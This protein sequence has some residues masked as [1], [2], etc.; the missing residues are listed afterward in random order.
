MSKHILVTSALPYANGSIHLGHILEAVQTDIWV[1]FQKL[2]GNE[3]YFFCADDTHGTPIMI[4][5]KKAGKTPESMIEE[6]QKEHYKDLT[7]F[8]VEYDNYYT[9]NSEENKKFSESIY[10]TLKKNG[11]IVARNI[12]QSYCEHDKMFLPDRFIKGTC[13]K[14]G[15]KDQYGDSCEV[16]GTSYSPKDLKDSY[17][18]ICGTTP[19]LRES[20]H[21]FFKLQDFQNQL[22]T[23]MEEGNRLNEGAQ[24]KLQEWFTSGLQEWDI[25]RDG[26]YFGFAIPEEENKYFYVW[27]DAPIGYM[28]SSLNHLKD[29]KKFN[30]FWKEGKG[31]IVHFIGKDILY[32]HGLFWPAMLMGSGYKAPSQLNVHGFLTVN[33][34][35][36][37][38]S[39]GTFINASTFA[40]YLDVE[41]FRFYLACRLGSGMED[42]DISFDDFVSRVNSDLIGNLVNLVSRVSTSILDKMDRKLG[43]LSTEGKSLVSELL[44]KETEIREAYE[45]RNYSKVMRE[46]TGLGD[47]V[48]KYVND[49][50]P[51]NL[52]KTDVEKAREVVTTSLNCAKI[53]FTYL[54]PVT[55]KIVH[56]LADLF[57]IPNLS[58]L[59]LTETIENKVLGPYQML[60][61]RVEEKNITIMITETKETFE[62]SNPEKAKQDPSKSNTNEV[63]SATVSEDGFITIDELSKV[64]L[65]VGLIKEA[66]P[67]EGADKLLFVKVDLGE[68]GI[69]NVFAGIKASYTA[70]E[71]VGKKVVVVANLKPR[72][73]KF[74]LSEAMLLA[75]GKDKTLSLFVPDRDASPG[76]LLK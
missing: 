69:K 41:H 29:E 49:Y 51:W 8:G 35:K 11:H 34:E 58:F 48:N 38:K 25:S 23:W 30:E 61:K 46:I 1:R 21:L 62:K 57:Q 5:A 13:P 16:C 9:T 24:K 36:M 20:K 2:I 52:I 71:L 73:M 40:K 75:S 3:C 26:P 59:N 17:C 76:D 47:K 54:A 18:S 50:A 14:C 31:E 67:V 33:G 63:K 44:S 64:E 55:P 4:A 74:G 19:V 7:S 42:V 45:S 28:A 6:V 37:S 10:L 32:F 39:R 56:S 68:K 65:R 12:E 72:Q 60:S 66:N 53:L 22:K 27:L 43:N 70:E 15:A